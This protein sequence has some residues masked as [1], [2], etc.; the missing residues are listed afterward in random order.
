MGALPRGTLEC[1]KAVRELP[2]VV[3][4]RC[5]QRLYGSVE[6]WPLEGWWLGRT[7]IDAANWLDDIHE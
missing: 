3:V 1:L 2:G 7:P 4:V 5:D 6:R